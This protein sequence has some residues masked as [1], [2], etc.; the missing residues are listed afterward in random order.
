MFLSRA[1]NRGLLL[2]VALGH[3]A[4]AL[5]VPLPRPDAA[6]PRSRLRLPGR[7][8]RRR[9]LLLRRRTD[10]LLRQ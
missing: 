1:G 8:A 7:R 9:H 10:E 5:G 3:T 4:G 2:L 6:A